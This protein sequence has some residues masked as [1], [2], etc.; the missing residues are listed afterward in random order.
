MSGMGQVGSCLT[1]LYR[2]TGGF[3]IDTD[4]KMTENGQQ[5]KQGPAMKK[6]NRAWLAFIYWI[7]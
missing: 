7:I 1:K 3:Q 6:A 2:L 4:Q 5:Q